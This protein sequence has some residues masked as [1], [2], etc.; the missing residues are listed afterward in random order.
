MVGHRPDGMETRWTEPSSHT[1]SVL[2]C[3]WELRWMWRRKK[4]IIPGYQWKCHCTN[5]EPHA[6][7]GTET[8]LPNILSQ[9]RSW[10]SVC[11]INGVYW[12]LITCWVI[13]V[14]PNMKV[15][16]S[17]F[18]GRKVRLRGTNFTKDTLSSMMLL[19]FEPKSIRVLC[20]HS[21]LSNYRI[22]SPNTHFTSKQG[23]ECGKNREWKGYKHP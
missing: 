23:A 5:T 6:I 7:A 12:R 4:Q 14:N 11:W 13:P 15:S 8:I 22:L 21:F 1:S 2:H 3:L 20:L 17:S 10:R 16:G 18:Q 9:P 19:W